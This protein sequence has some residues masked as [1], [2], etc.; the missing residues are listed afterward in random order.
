MPTLTTLEKLKVISCFVVFLCC[1]LPLQSA[2]GQVVFHVAEGGSD[3]GPG[4]AAQPFATLARARDAVR[5]CEARGSQRVEVVLAAGRYRRTTTLGLGVNDGGSPAAEVIYRA[6]KGAT[7]ILDGGIEIPVNRCEPVTDPAIKRRL[8][9]KTADKVLVVDLKQLGVAE[10]AS[11][12][13]RGFGRP[14]IPAPNELFVNGQPQRPARWPNEGR[15]KLGEVIDSGS[16]PRQGDDANRGAVFKYQTDRALRWTEANDVHISGIFGQSWADDTIKVAAI[17]T[18][19][20]TI[21]TAGA[22][23]YGFRNR[24]FTTWCVVN[25]LEEIDQPGEF[26]VD[27]AAGRL[28]FYPS[29]PNVEQLQLS[30]MATPFVRI[31]GA[32]HLRIEGI[33]FENARGSGIEVKDGN[34]VVIA[35]C[36]LRNLG[37][38]AIRVNGGTGHVVRRCDI[39]HT[40]AGGV[41]VAGGDRK[42]LTPARHLVENCDIHRVNRWYWTYRPCIRLSG[43]GN[44][45]RHNH[46]HHVPG[47]GHPVRRQRPPDRIQRNRP[48]RDG[49]VRHGRDLHRAQS[50]RARACH[51][52]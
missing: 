21:R 11:F 23:L 52:L 37:S 1:M 14:L 25:L 51:S 28:Y 19:A 45:A 27:R 47:Q 41:S 40:G 8:V 35:D 46:L 4:T 20:G 26:F 12:G 34:A 30:V 18:E 39:Y 44:A 48:L 5:Q 9:A 33:T 13:E 10:L 42:N 22:H 16:V 36:T 15:I 6:A 7:V 17:D 38:H 24:G 29:Q 3:D 50:Q 31:N 49:H 43:V 32:S 2:M